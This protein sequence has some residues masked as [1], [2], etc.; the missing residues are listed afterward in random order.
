M[1][2]F[3]RCAMGELLGFTALV[4]GRASGLVWV[5]PIQWQ[6]LHSGRADRLPGGAG[7]EKASPGSSGQPSPSRPGLPPA[8]RRGKAGLEYLLGELPA[9]CI[10]NLLSQDIP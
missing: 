7:P 10:S 6:G 1:Y 8:S 2:T 4:R 3:A 9:W 5:N